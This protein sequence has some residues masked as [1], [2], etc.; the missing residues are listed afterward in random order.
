MSGIGGGKPGI[1]AFWDYESNQVIPILEDDNALNN[2]YE[3]VF[4]NLK[5][6]IERLEKRIE[7]LETAYMEKILLGENK[8]GNV[9]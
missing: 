7:Q 1:R 9:T 5:A 3:S 4:E 2:T 8:D 6:Q